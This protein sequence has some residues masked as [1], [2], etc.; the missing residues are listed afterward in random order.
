M[1]HFWREKSE[2]NI[3]ILG[4]FTTFS[5]AFLK[6]KDNEELQGLYPKVNW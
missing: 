5:S 2:K 4:N 3:F 1:T 6:S